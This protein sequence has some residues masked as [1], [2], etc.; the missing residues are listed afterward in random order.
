MGAACA[1][2][3][4][5]QALKE[6]HPSILRKRTITTTGCKAPGATLQQNR[7]RRLV[8]NSTHSRAQHF[9]AWLTAADA[10]SIHDSSHG[11]I[12][13]QRRNGSN[14]CRLC[15]EAICVGTANARTQENK[16]GTHGV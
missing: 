2:K 7:A 13:L 14:A 3:R 1:S 12:A 8:R 15:K 9:H 6:A 11:H 16:N 10:Q 5:T 4:R